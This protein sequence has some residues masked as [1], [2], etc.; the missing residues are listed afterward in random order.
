MEHLFSV[1]FISNFLEKCD[2][3]INSVN[4][5][6]NT[7]METLVDKISADLDDWNSEDPKTLQKMDENETRSKVVLSLILKSGA[8]P[9]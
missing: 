4:S 7:V 3:N 8:D 2:F 6:G 1:E 9:L 5:D